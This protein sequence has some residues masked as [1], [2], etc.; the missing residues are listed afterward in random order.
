MM[1]VPC[2]GCGGGPRAVPEVPEERDHEHLLEGQQV[3]GDAGELLN[4]EGEE[5]NAMSRCERLFPELT[6]E[7]P[8]PS[9]PKQ[10]K[11]PAERTPWGC[12][13]SR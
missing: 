2:L 4:E 1:S 3:D 11:A 8:V 9:V 10:Q 7:K 13:H 6:W 5:K 12:E